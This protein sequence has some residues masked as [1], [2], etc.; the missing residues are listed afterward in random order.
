MNYYERI[1]NSIDFM[2]ENLE[3]KIK[4]SEMA[5]QAFMSESNYY[6]IFFAITGYQAKEYLIHRRISCASRQLLDGHSKIIDVAMKYAYDSVDAFSR[7]FKRV[8]GF[9][10]SVYLA[11]NEYY[12]FEKIDV[13]EKYFSPSSKNMLEQYP[14]IK[15]LSKLPNMRVAYY[16]YY[17]KNPEDGAFS[18]MKRWIMEQKH[19]SQEVGYRIFGYDAPGTDSRSEEYGY[20][21]C[22]TIPEDM[23]VEDELVRTKVLPGGLFA[24]ISID[25]P[26]NQ[27]EEIR[28]GWHRFVQ[29]LEGSRYLH[30]EAQYLEE[31]LGFDEDL[32]HL[33]GIDLYLPIKER[34]GELCK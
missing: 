22:V 29:W 3:K 26:D 18:V 13:M 11:R 1:Q 10:P 14:D 4:V 15:V 31:H 16:C 27:G 19:G 5:K 30:R 33:G 6:R 32:E 17:G 12:H 24:V 28:A 7:T 20:E 23:I 2:E 9:V 21:V 8:T 25:P 34:G